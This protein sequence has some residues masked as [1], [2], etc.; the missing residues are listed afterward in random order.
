MNDSMNTVTDSNADDVEARQHEAIKRMN[1]IANEAGLGLTYQG[2]L[3]ENEHLKRQSEYANN[4]A[5][6][7]Q[8]KID[9]VEEWLKESIADDDI[10]EAIAETLA[11]MLGIELT[12]ESVM[13]I[14]LEVRVT[15]KIGHRD[16]I[17][18]GNLTI[19]VSESYG[20]DAEVEV[21]E[22]E[23]TDTEVREG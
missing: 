10:P 1:E 12:E 4:R 6:N 21:L 2:L 18:D 7:L 8:A 3:S 9:S 5:R 19:S 13:T 20:G 22:W 14:T 16:S 23:V 11:D 15:H 17:D